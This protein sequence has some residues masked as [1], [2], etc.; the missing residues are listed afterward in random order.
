MKATRYIYTI[1]SGAFLMTSCLSSTIG[2]GQDVIHINP[3]LGTDVRSAGNLKPDVERLDFGVYAVTEGGEKYID[4]EYLSFKGGRWAMSEDYIWPQDGSLR[5]LA[6]SPFKA[7]L[8]LTS[9]RLTVKGFTPTESDYTLLTAD[10]ERV[11]NKQGGEV[12][13][14]FYP[15]TSSLDF[16]VANSLNQETVVKLEKIVLKGIYLTGSLSEKEQSEWVLEGEKNDVVVYDSASADTS[17]KAGTETV[18]RIPQ[19]FGRKL[20]VLPQMSLPVAEVTYSLSTAGSG[21]L[22]GQVQTTDVLISEWAAGRK[23]TYTLFITENKVKHTVG[24]T[25][26]KGEIIEK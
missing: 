20:N 17:L 14:E 6:Y 24:I 11:L 21:W 16:R 19:W 22:T 9:N 1:I 7:S 15:A 5:F 23:Y 2:D 10:T 13:L 12:S 25:D 18:E 3:V 4:N 26:W 8:S